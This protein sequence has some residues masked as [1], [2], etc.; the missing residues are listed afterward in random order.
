MQSRLYKLTVTKLVKLACVLRYK[1]QH[2]LRRC[3]CKFHAVFGLA[4]AFSVFPGG[5]LRQQDQQTL[6]RIWRDKS[7][8]FQTYQTDCGEPVVI[9]LNLVLARLHLFVSRAFSGRNF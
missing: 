6:V 4:N 8:I 5:S 3:R 7:D 9:V 2:I 1:R